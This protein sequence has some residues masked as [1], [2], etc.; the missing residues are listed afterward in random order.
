MSVGGQPAFGH[1]ARLPYAAIAAPDPYRVAH[2][3]AVGGDV[4][5]VEVTRTIW[6]WIHPVRLGS[7]T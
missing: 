6:A 2:V 3:N 5:N 7:A 4:L 1:G